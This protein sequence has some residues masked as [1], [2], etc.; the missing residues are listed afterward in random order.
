MVRISGD[1]A[2]A[3]RGACAEP[4]KGGVRGPEE[5]GGWGRGGLPRGLRLLGVCV[6]ANLAFTSCPRRGALGV[7]LRGLAGTRIERRSAVGGQF[8]GKKPPRRTSELLQP[9]SVC[10]FLL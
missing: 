4:P 7:M 10:R 2:G 6:G 8:L 5:Q 1:L 3:R 9:L